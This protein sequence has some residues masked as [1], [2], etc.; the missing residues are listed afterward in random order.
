MLDSAAAG[1]GDPG[2]G[3]AVKDLVDQRTGWQQRL[4]ATLY[5]LGAPAQRNLRAADRD[6]LARIAGLSPAAR[7]AITVGLAMIEALDAQIAP[8]RA[9]L[10]GFTRRQPGC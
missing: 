8:L 6:R 4:H 5:H 1:V 2:Q 3:P 7:Q 10:T 9:E